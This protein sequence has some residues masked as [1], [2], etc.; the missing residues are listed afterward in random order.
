MHRFPN[1]CLV[2]AANLILLAHP[3]VAALQPAADAPL[4]GSVEYRCHFNADASSDCETR[5]RYTILQPAGREILSRIDHSYSEQDSLTVEKA[6]VTQ[7]GAQSTP[8]AASN[9]DTRMAPHPEQGFLSDKQTSLA[10]PNLKVGTTI[11]YTLRQHFSPRPANPEF[12]YVLIWTPKP[13]R[14]DRI[15]AEITAERPIVWRGEL[16]QDY[17]VTHSAEGRKLVLELKK[18]PYYINYVNESEAGYARRLPRLEAGSSLDVQDHFATLATRYNEILSVRLP[19]RAAAAVAA[20]RGKAPA[21]QIAAFMQYIYDNYR[22]LGDWRDSERGHIPFTLAEIESR[23]YGDCKDLAVLLGAML[24][25]AGIPAEPALIRRGSYAPSLL[26]PGLYA[27][28]H[29][30]VRVAA[31]G[32]VWWLD[33]TN[34]VFA[35]G[36]IMPDLQQRWVVVLGADGKAR[37]DETPRHGPDEAMRAELQIRYLAEDKART[38]LTLDFAHAPLINIAANERQIGRASTD[39]QLCSQ[40]ARESVDCILD[41][42]EPGFVV[43][44]SYRVKADLTALRPLRRVGERLFTDPSMSSEWDIFFRYISEGQ[45]LDLYLGEPQTTSYDVTLLAAK[46]D[47][48]ARA[49]QVRSKWYDLDLQ[50]EPVAAGYHYRYRLV[51]KMD[52]FGHEDIMDPEF[53]QMIGQ[54]RDC[55]EQL[56]MAVQLA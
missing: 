56:R 6:E 4:S 49:C 29:A 9:I 43:P 55:T 27:P 13:V 50:G 30:I 36:H 45:R 33:P 51:R 38:H 14:Y 48:P 47:A 28:D 17:T 46:I 35:P 1:R 8:L 44:A 11:R 18:A 22:Y 32:Q 53:R 10:F 12:H 5:Y 16:L 40:F 42:P 3:A 15:W 37:L 41:R 2:L 24:R 20:A 21:K 26:I 7:P 54:A 25:A 39:R 19:E 23:G 52:W 31:G 34:S